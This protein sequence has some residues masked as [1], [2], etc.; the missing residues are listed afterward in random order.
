MRRYLPGAV[1]TF[2]AGLLGLLF[3]YLS[4]LWVWPTPLKIAYDKGDLFDVHY[5]LPLPYVSYDLTFDPPYPYPIRSLAPS[6][7]EDPF[8]MVWVNLFVDLVFRFLV[9]LL[10]IRLFKRVPQSVA[11][12]TTLLPSLLFSALVLSACGTGA[13]ESAG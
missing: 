5:G 7:W 6:P 1:S 12:P 2:G 4:G 3:V 8:E 13:G 9:S 11:V 10:L